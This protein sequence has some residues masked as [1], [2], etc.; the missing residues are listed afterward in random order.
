MSDKIVTTYL[1]IEAIP[2]AVK[3]YWRSILALTL[4]GTAVFAFVFIVALSFLG[5][6]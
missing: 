4:L 1:Y 5:D 6:V 2:R 3:L